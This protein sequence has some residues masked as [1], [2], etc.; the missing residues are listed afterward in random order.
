MSQAIVWRVKAG[1]SVD[2][3]AESFTRRGLIQSLQVR[4]VIGEDGAETGKY[5]VPAGERRYRGKTPGFLNHMP[6]FWA[7]LARIAVAA[8]NPVVTF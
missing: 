8:A 7:A 4:S 2:E 3:L 5:E 6:R 1:V